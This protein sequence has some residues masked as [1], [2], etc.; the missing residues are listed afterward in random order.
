MA[1]EKEKVSSNNFKSLVKRKSKS[2]YCSKKETRFAYRN[3]NEKEQ[4]RQGDNKRNK[5]KRSNLD[6]D[7][8]EYL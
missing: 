2:M 8:K 6:S 3:D 4:L 7:E 5:K 1:K